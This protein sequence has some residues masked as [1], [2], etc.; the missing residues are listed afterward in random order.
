MS[1]GQLQNKANTF[2]ISCEDTM[3]SNKHKITSNKRLLDIQ[4]VGFLWRAS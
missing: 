1:E 2:N 4:C 3:I